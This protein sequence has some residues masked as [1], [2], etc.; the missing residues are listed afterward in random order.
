MS[1][2][3]IIGPMKSGKSI[4]LL[5]RVAPYSYANKTVLLVQP[6]QNVRDTGITSRLGLIKE[7]LKVSSLQEITSEFDVIGIDEVHMFDPTDVEIIQGWALANKQVF[8]SG[9]D[10]GYDGRMMRVM[11]RIFE[12]KPDTIIDKSAVCEDCKE[13]CAR[14]TKIQ[15]N[16]KTLR[17]GL[18]DVVPEDGTYVYKANCRRC[19][20]KD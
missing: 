5:A 13:Y 19:F 8:V 12:L 2:I 1:L 17:Q 15:K 6:K 10:V 4:E 3:A 20:L 14:F 9:L 18:P 16:G 11:K 7:A